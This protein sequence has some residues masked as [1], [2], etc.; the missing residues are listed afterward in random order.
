MD[1]PASTPVTTPLPDPI[2][3]IVVALL[4]HEPPAEPSV[5]FVVNPAQ[6]LSVPVIAEGNGL[7]VAIA[8][9]IHPVGKV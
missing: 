8:V 7:T 1:V 5:K 6:T 4:V 3:A 2:V 9:I